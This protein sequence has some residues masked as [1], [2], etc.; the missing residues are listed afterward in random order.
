[1]TLSSAKAIFAMAYW[2]EYVSQMPDLLKK[3]G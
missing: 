2:R 1:M 3:G